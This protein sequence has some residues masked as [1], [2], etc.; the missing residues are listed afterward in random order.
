MKRTASMLDNLRYR[1]RVR[2]GERVTYWLTQLCLMGLGIGTL[3]YVGEHFPSDS[4]FPP[5]TYLAA[6]SLLGI[7]SNSLRNYRED[8][9]DYKR[10]QKAQWERDASRQAT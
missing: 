1:Y 9:L 7:V 8:L 4:V 10:L 2:W 3:A 5:L 6:I